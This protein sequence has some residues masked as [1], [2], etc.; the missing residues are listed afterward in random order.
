MRA[1]FPCCLTTLQTRETEPAMPPHSLMAGSPMPMSAGSTL[2]CFPGEAKGPF[3]TATGEGLGQP[4]HQLQ[5]LR[6]EGRRASYCHLCYHGADKKGATSSPILT[7]SGPAHRYLRQVLCCAVET[8]TSDLGD[9]MASASV[10]PSPLQICLPPVHMTHSASRSHM[11][12]IESL[13]P[14]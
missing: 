12:L 13:T 8:W 3:S 4:P 1:S 6:G 11:T 7:A 5:V 14:G 2:L 9:S 10:P